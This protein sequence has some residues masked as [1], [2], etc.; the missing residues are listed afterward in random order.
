MTWVACVALAGTSDTVPL[1]AK[2]DG[3]LLPL[4]AFSRLLR[5]VTLQRLAA[6]VAR[7]DKTARFAH[8][9]N[10]GQATVGYPE[11]GR[12]GSGI[13][14]VNR[15]VAGD[16]ASGLQQGPAGLETPWTVPRAMPTPAI[17]DKEGLL[18]EARRFGGAV[19]VV[20]HRWPS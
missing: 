14:P 10:P 20:R 7:P 19:S 6:L 16:A 5:A 12:L 3:E 17:S 15:S 1:K 9:L 2:G 18:V 8:R 11:T 13:V 4:S